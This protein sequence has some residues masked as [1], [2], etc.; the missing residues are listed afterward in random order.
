MTERGVGVGP[1]IVYDDDSGEGGPEGHKCSSLYEI[2][3]SLI[4]GGSQIMTFYG[5]HI[6]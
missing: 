6:E 2:K 4:M 3:Y 1:I 5:S